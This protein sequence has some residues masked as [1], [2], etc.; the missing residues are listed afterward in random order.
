MTRSQ[1]ENDMA[2]NFASIMDQSWENIPEIK[3]LPVGSYRLRNRG[4]QYKEPM[5][6]GGDPFIL[7][8]YQVVE[9]MSDVDEAALA[10][11]GD[12]YDLKGNRVFVRQYINDSSDWQQ[13]RNFLAKHGVEAKGD[14]NTTLKEMKNKEAVAYL[15]QR[16]FT[17]MAGEARTE[18]S[19]SPA[20][21]VTPEAA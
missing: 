8:I 16:S 17:S 10:A 4:A 9:A 5:K 6:E 7:Y 18:N 21:F 13:V 15:D 1:K 20:S 12:N 2:S 3:L 14:I 19:A 11:L